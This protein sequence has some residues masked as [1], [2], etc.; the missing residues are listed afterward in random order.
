MGCCNS[1]TTQTKDNIIVPAIQLDQPYDIIC[2]VEIS[3]RIDYSQIAGYQESPN[4]I[5]INYY[6][7][8]PITKPVKSP[9]ESSEAESSQD[10]VKIH[11]KLVFSPIGTANFNF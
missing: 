7:D 2:Q 6:K 11:D 10:Q 3:T 8:I 5:D 9:V 4:Y 1:K